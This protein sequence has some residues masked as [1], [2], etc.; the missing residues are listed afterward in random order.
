M[1]APDPAVVDPAAE[2]PS[3]GTRSFGPSA[4]IGILG[5]GQLGRMLALAARRM[6]YGVITFGDDP[7]G[8]PCGQVAEPIDD[9]PTFLARADVVTT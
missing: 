2:P 6:G 8:S 4:T 3:T 1:S 5:T 7:P 9:L